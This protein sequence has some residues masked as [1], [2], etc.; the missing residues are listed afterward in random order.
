MPK[1]SSTM[2]PAPSPF[3]TV[4]NS[5]LKRLSD[6]MINYVVKLFCNCHLETAAYS[7]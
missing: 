3:K 5:Q 1:F 7:L 6:Y 2:L 4:S